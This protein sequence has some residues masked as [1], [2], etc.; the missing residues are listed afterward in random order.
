MARCCW[1]GGATEVTI[2]CNREC[3]AGPGEL[4]VLLV[5]FAVELQ[6]FSGQEIISEVIEVRGITYKTPTTCVMGVM[7]IRF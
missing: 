6:F 7:V 3:C 2:I 1:R 4:I 5:F